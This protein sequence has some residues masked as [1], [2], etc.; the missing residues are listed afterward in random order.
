M[1]NNLLRT[2]RPT[3]QPADRPTDRASY[4]DAWMHLKS[5]F[6]STFHETFVKHHHDANKQVCRSGTIKLIFGKNGDSGRKSSLAYCRCGS[7]CGQFF[8]VILGPP[9]PQD[10]T[11]AIFLGIQ[12]FFALLSPK[13]HERSVPIDEKDDSVYIG[14]FRLKCRMIQ[15]VGQLKRQDG[16]T[17]RR[18]DWHSLL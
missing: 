10:T 3:D 4:R 17:D 12:P 16:R 14:W 11:P 8:L 5:F 13:W 15:G 1:K 2:D 9:H 18:T 7:G 6:L